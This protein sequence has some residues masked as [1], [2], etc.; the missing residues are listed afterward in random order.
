MMS[1]R[2]IVIVSIVIVLGLLLAFAASL[3]SNGSSK[4]SPSRTVPAAVPTQGPTESDL[5]ALAA[6]LS[7]GDNARILAALADLPPAADAAA[8]KSLGSLKSVTFDASTLRFDAPTGA[9]VVDARLV[10][11]SGKARREREVLVKRDGRWLLYSSLIQATQ[12]GAPVG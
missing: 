11:T 8:L 7:S 10:D 6:E 2:W 5:N 1:R 9:A 12:T 3:V 4:P